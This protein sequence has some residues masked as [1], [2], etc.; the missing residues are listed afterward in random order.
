MGN[1]NIQLIRKANWNWLNLSELL[2]NDISNGHNSYLG[3]L[4]WLLNARQCAV[5]A[6]E[7][8]GSPEI[9]N[10][11]SAPLKQVKVSS[12]CHSLSSRTNSFVF[13]ERKKNYQKHFHEMYLFWKITPWIWLKNSLETTTEMIHLHKRKNTIQD[14]CVEIWKW[15]TKD[16]F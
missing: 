9:I 12:Y 15:K 11:N 14:A 5:T 8:L 2:K 1:L 3:D 16:D 7:K 4:S 10:A 6:K 13:C